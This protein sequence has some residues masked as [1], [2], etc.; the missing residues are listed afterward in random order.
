VRP[1]DGN[2]A[3][4]TQTDNSG[5]FTIAGLTPGRYDVQITSAGFKQTSKQIELQPREIAKVDSRLEVG[6]VAESV[7]V[8]AEAT[9]VQPLQP[10]QIDPPSLP[11]NAK[12]HM[13]ARA[14]SLLPTKLPAV[15]TAANGGL[16]LAADTGGALFLSKDAGKTWESVAPAWSGKAIHVISPPNPPAPSNVL[17]QLTTDSGA[18]WLSRDGTHWDPA[19]SKR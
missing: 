3:S 19:P 11:L 15:T 10:L 14:V 12:A 2:S 8:M 9:L 13:F 7:T 6:Q 1:I 5:R 17:F 4:N 18:V 16:T